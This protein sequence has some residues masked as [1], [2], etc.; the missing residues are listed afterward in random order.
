[1]F[2]GNYSSAEYMLR[3][4]GPTKSLKKDKS[5]SFF[6]RVELASLPENDDFS[7]FILQIKDVFTDIEM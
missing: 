2:V 6:C 3:K 7:D 1:M 5:R 4:K